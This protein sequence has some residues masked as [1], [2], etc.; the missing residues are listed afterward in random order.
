MRNAVILLILAGLLAAQTLHDGFLI[1]GERDEVLA[2]QR[3]EHY[4][5]G[6]ESLRSYYIRTVPGDGT[7]PSIM[8]RSGR[9][10]LYDHNLVLRALFAGYLRHHRDGSLL[11]IFDNALFID[12]GSAI[13]NG[14]GAPTCRD[15]YEDKSVY[16]YLHRIIATDINDPESRYVDTYVRTRNNLPFEVRAV[17]LALDTPE[18]MDALVQ[19]KR[20]P[21]IFRSANSGPD[22]YYSPD[23]LT[24]HFKAMISQA[25]NRPLLYLF[26]K[27]LLYKSR[28]SP[29]FE[30]I[31]EVDYDVGFNHRFPGWTTVNWNARTLREAFSSREKRVL[32]LTKPETYDL[33]SAVIPSKTQ[34]KSA[35]LD[36]SLPPAD[37]VRAVEWQKMVHE[38]LPHWEAE[39]DRRL[40]EALT[41][42]ASHYTQVSRQP[43]E[44]LAVIAKF[45]LTLMK[46]DYRRIG[47][48][49]Y[50]AATGKVE[51]KK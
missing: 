44:S 21:L 19:D 28:T 43:P 29:G 8:Q 1:S 3:S 51:L 6:P 14:E 12:I 47:K 41:G 27:Y 15:L 16:N 34:I 5:Y 22:L 18:K 7:G 30:I 40:A 35:D 49:R 37:F 33:A 23:V 45:A 13:L 2:Y 20:H 24:G 50:D 36:T 32:V 25:G 48:L 39:A 46:Y 17:P 38:D 42:V 11:P 26:G 10:R 9:R 4:G 31:G